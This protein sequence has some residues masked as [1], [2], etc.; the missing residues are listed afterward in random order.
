MAIGPVVGG[1][2]L[3][4][5]GWDSIFLVNLPLTASRLPWALAR[6]RVA[7]PRCPAA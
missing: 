6:A 3:A 7:R 4:H 5:F 1:V 2:L